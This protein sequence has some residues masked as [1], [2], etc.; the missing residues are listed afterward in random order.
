MRFAHGRWD[1]EQPHHVEKVSDVNGKV[2]WGRCSC[3]WEGDLRTAPASA[4]DDC[5]AHERFV[6]ETRKAGKRLV[7]GRVE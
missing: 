5:I 4:D 3:G 7:R 2:E 6:F 1:R